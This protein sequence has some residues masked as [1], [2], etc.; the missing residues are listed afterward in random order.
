MSQMSEKALIGRALA[1][2]QRAFSSLYQAYQPRILGMVAP[3]AEDRDEAEDVV[4]VT[5]VKAFQSLGNFRG[6]A[7]FSTWLTRIAINVCNSHQRTRWARRERF[8]EVKDIDTCLRVDRDRV[9]SDTPEDV[10]SRKE[11]REIVMN[12][13]QELPQQYREAMWLRYVKELTY[14]EITR[15]LD[16]PM[17]TVK[18]WLCRGRRILEG[19]PCIQ[20]FLAM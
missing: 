5:L 19:E 14:L 2:D 10:V 8:Q 16:V 18:T 1:G 13:I 17:G 7:A 9:R 20:Q 12:C 11:R 4:Q 15:A 6:E 3:R